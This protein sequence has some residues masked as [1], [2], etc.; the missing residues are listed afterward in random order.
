MHMLSSLS[1]VKY[2]LG[3]QTLSFEAWPMAFPA[4]ITLH[5]SLYPPPK[6]HN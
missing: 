3:R 6:G 2:D 1:V 4:K 5:I